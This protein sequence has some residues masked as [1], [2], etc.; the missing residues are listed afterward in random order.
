MTKKD[1][2]P[3]LAKLRDGRETVRE[4]EE[5]IDSLFSVITDYGFWVGWSSREPFR[6]GKLSMTGVEKFLPKGSM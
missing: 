3:T 2:P 5:G 6:F 4:G 1:I